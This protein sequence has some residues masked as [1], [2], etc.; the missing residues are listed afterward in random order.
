MSKPLDISIL[1]HAASIKGGELLS[2][3]YTSL[4]TKYKWKCDKGHIWHAV[5][6]PI[7][8]G[9]AWCAQCSGRAKYTG[10]RITDIGKTKGFTLVSNVYDYKNNKTKL[11]WL[12]KNNHLFSSRLNDIVTGYGCPECGG[13]KIPDIS[14]LKS[15]AISR[16]GELLSEVYVNCETKYTW[17][18][19]KKHT[20]EASW[21]LISAGQWCP[22]CK[23]YATEFKCK[24]ILESLTGKPFNKCRII[25][26]KQSKLELDGYNEEMNIA[27]EYNGIQHYKQC[28]WLHKTKIDFE[29]QQEK[30]MF[31][32]KW[33]IDNNIKLIVIP[34]T[35]KKTLNQYIEKELQKCLL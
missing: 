26:F 5:P 3:I 13:V 29:Y 21:H 20:W 17:S 18:C 9:I 10:D 25:P 7:I 1:R 33:C 32:H 8:K 15:C 23:T 11:Q 12:C 27:F 16:E 4:R 31:K 28:S 19:K 34:Y 14:K 35:E 2:T 22:L 6:W 24:Q 30:D